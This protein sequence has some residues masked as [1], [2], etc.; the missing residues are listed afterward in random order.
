MGVH[1]DTTEIK[2]LT[3]DIS[4]MPLAIQRR[5]PDAMRELGREAQRRWRADSRQQDLPHGKHYPK[6]I[7]NELTEAGLAVEIGP[8]SHRPQGGM[9]A[10]FE[11]GSRNQPPHLSGNKM[12]DRMEPKIP[13]RIT[14]AVM[15][16]IEDT[17]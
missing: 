6:A 7:T 10:G 14:K 11:Y 4:R 2:T 8:E 9:G 15:R 13:E 17:I 1:I 5:V 12:A 16:G 3:H